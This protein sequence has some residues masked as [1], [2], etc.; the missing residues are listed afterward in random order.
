MNILNMLRDKLNIGRIGWASRGRVPR[1]STKEGRFGAETGRP[2]GK[3]FY[4]EYILGFS[5]DAP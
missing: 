4:R 2:L 1:P 3:I 5:I